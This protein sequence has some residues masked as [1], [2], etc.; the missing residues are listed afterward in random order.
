MEPETK[1]K[2]KTILLVEDDQTIREFYATAL[3]K[4]G[5]EVILATDGKEGVE[6]A[7]QHKPAVILLDIDM[8][9]MDGHEA[10]EQ[11]RFDKKWGKEVPIIFLT[12]H[13][14]ATNVAHAHMLHPDDYIVKANTPTKELIN[15]VRTAMHR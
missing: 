7:L 2:T 9:I 10:A 5:L 15:K 13:S 6:K 1:V 4:E 12:N 14:D 8:P 11:I 3:I